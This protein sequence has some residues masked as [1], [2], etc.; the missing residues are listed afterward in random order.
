MLKRGQ[1]LAINEILDFWFTDIGTGFNVTA[2]KGIW[3]SGDK[4]VDR[5]I[6]QRFGSM[7][8]AAKNGLL[9]LWEADH[10]GCLALVLLLDQFNRNIY[11]GRA[12]AFSGDKMALDI[13]KMALAKQFDLLMT[14]VQR[15]FFY[16]PFEHSELLS[17]QNRAINLFKQL[18]AD[19]PEEGEKTIQSSLNFA[20]KH[21][22]IIMRFGRFPHRNAVLSRETTVEER[23]YLEEGGARFGQ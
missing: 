22:D 17:N 19:V 1:A 10:R 13:A 12:D 3:W 16:M 5:E 7:V 20:E 11:R 15:S 6:D 9:Y 8:A 2:Q 4:A 23:A 18:L 21:R 14:P